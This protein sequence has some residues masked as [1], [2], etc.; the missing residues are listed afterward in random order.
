MVTQSDLAIVLRSVAYEDRHRIIT[1]L[2]LQSGQ[3]SA[4]AKNSIQSRR[5]GGS[6]EL[7][8]ASDWTYTTRPGAELH[9]LTETQ[10]REPFDQLRKD[11]TLLALASTL[12]ELVLKVAPAQEA[13]PDLFRLHYNALAALNETAQQVKEID[14][15][16]ALTFLNAYM[17]KLLQLSGQQP[18]LH[19]CLEC[20]LSLSEMNSKIPLSC[21]IHAAGWVCPSC[22]RQKKSGTLDQFQQAFMEIQPIAILT[23]QQN[24]QNP[25]RRIEALRQGKPKPSNTDQQALF[26]FLEALYIYHVPGFDKMVLKSLRFL[27]LESTL[28]PQTGN[29]RQK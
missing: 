29:P 26:N 7:F 4:M 1:A 17:G 6:L 16:F 27:H 8:A 19:E 20:G 21:V 22:R 12:N 15:A 10:I 3:I 25:I 28:T 13:C 9:Q 23:L 5:F 2:T 18:R 24:L 11:F 14:P